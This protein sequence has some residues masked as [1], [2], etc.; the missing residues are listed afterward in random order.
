[1]DTIPAEIGDYRIEI[2]LHI[3]RFD[4]I[5]TIG[6]GSFSVVALVAD[7]ATQIQ[8]ACKICS[9][10][11]LL[12]QCIFD[13]F[14]REV[15]LMQS[16]RHPSLVAIED[17]V[18]DQ[19]LI[20]L[21][22][23]YCFNGELFQVIAERGVLDE[24][25]SRRIFAQISEGVAYIHSHNIAHRDIKPE[26]I[27]LDAEMNAKITD[28]GLCHQVDPN[29]LLKTP[30][31]S[32][33]YAPPEIISNQPYDGKLSDVWSLGVVLYT[34]VTGALPWKE[35]NQMQLYRQIID[36]N[37][38]I[39][40]NLSLT[41]RDL[42]SRLMR[43]DPND[44]LPVTEILRHPWILEGEEFMNSSKNFGAL[45]MNTALG[46]SDS[47]QSHSSCLKNKPL[48]IRP[49]VANETNFSSF[50]GS[51]QMKHILR[52]VPPSRKNQG[53]FVKNPISSVV[54]KK[55]ANRPAQ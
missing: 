53:S 47:K 35:S 29:N 10:Q 4:Y 19:N 55:K 50:G 41:L 8:Y 1:M 54:I 45:G 49:N 39:P 30:C 9:R 33:F 14:E 22:M 11:Q 13:R 36:A 12:E 42:I 5:R 21:V 48:I 52:R 38:I 6:S 7:R 46:A 25:T 32:P 23:E 34:M 44:R 20:Y 15:R 51:S 27:L 43:P 24:N 28:F 16:F 37:F 17:V 2:P 40:R 3:G 18:Y 26:N 31:G